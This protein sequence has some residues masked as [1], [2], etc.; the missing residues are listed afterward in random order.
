V[1][2]GVSSTFPQSLTPPTSVGF[3]ARAVLRFARGARQKPPS[4][5]TRNTGSPT[6]LLRIFMSILFPYY[7]RD[8]AAEFVLCSTPPFGIEW[9]ITFLSEDA[10]ARKRAC[11]G[12]D[13]PGMAHVDRQKL[14]VL[15]PLTRKWS[16]DQNE[17]AALN[18]MALLML[19]HQFRPPGIWVGKHC[20]RAGCSRSSSVA[21]G[22]RPPPKM[23]V[24]AVVAFE[25]LT[26]GTRDILQHI[27]A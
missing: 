16:L 27:C 21:G 10:P 14:E 5:L 20:R 17:A 15:P 9:D 4:S 18:G 22:R 3:M 19:V 6:E 23:V 1:F 2:T 12:A 25:P 7:C 24:A 13:R 11:I 26:R 8:G